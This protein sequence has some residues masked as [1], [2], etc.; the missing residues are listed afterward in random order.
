MIKK[1]NHKIIFIILNFLVLILNLI[2]LF[3]FKR[4]K[5]IYFETKYK[6]RFSENFDVIFMNK[7][8]LEIASNLNN[9]FEKSYQN[10]TLQNNKNKKTIKICF[11]EFYK[12]YNP[13]SL[14]KYFDK[15]KF[16]FKFDINNPDYLIYNTFFSKNPYDKK[17]KNAIKIALSTE[18]K[19]PDFNEADY[20][21]GFIHLNYLD[22]YFKYFQNI[23]LKLIKYYYK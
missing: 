21:I 2:Y 9:K 19:I 6:F 20:A 3:N 16:I 14:I 8:N 10:F 15:E 12:G 17:Y 18:N 22:R 7:T 11:L 4:F 23:S 13:N 1:F 5:R